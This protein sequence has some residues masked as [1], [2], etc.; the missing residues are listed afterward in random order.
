[1]LQVFKETPDQPSAIEK[2]EINHKMIQLKKV[3]I[4][5]QTTTAD[6]CNDGVMLQTARAKISDLR[7]SS[8]ENARL[9]SL[10]YRKPTKLHNSTV[11]RKTK[12]AD[13]SN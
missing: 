11:Q 4:A 13:C 6:C 5:T 10:R 3:G 7:S 9:L 12:V 1:M 2:T 8:T